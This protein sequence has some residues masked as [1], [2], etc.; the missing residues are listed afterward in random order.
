MKKLASDAPSN[1]KTFPCLS[2]VPLISKPAILPA[3]AVICP[4]GV[5]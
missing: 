5:K 2:F 4:S 3:D 1:S